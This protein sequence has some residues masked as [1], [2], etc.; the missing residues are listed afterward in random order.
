MVDDTAGQ[1][2]DSGELENNDYETEYKSLMNDYS[3]FQSHEKE[4]F[5][6][7]LEE[8]DEDGI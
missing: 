2:R 8:K 1:N 5:N 7:E 4:K 3:N 6:S